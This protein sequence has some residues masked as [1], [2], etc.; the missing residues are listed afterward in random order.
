MKKL[1]FLSLSIFFTSM[2]FGDVQEVLVDGKK[3]IALQEQTQDQ[4]QDQENKTCPI[5]TTLGCA[6]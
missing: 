6:L 3:E 4:E 2:L 1:L 5:D